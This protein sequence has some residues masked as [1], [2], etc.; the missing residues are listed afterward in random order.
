[1]ETIENK[2]EKRPWCGGRKHR[3]GWILLGVVGVTAFALLFGAVVMW[4]WNGLMPAIFHLGVITYCQAI[5]LA[6]LGRLLFGGFHHGMHGRGR[7]GF[8]PW[9]HRHQLGEGTHC[10]DFSQGSKWSYYDQ[11][12]NEEGEQAFNEYLKR[13]N[14]KYPHE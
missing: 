1:M 5:G 3:A 4:L 12:W 8:G 13:F 9:K 14:L 2:F 6:V 11:Y 7:H 10:R